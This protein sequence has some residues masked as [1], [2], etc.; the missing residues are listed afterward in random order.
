[1]KYRLFFA[2]F[3]LSFLAGCSLLGGNKDTKNLV[4][5]GLTPKELYEQA[6]DKVDAGSIEQAIDFN[7]GANCKKVLITHHAPSRS[8]KELDQIAK[9]LPELFI[10]ARDGLE[11][12]V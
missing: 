11:I 12:E 5:D 6:E 3:L 7:I 10:L 1:M 2:F 8:D 9:D 4:A